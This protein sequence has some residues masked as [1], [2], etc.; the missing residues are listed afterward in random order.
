MALGALG[1]TDAMPAIARALAGELDGRTRRRMNE[2]I[3]EI[4]D[5]ARPAEEARRLHD[6][7]ERLRGETAKLR[8]RL[9]RLEA[10]L[11]AP[12][13]RPRRPRRSAPGRPPGAAAAPRAPP[14]ALRPT[15]AYVCSSATT[16]RKIWRARSSSP[17]GIEMAPTTGW[18][19][20]P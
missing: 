16:S 3:R 2:A 18:P 8:E 5:G 13:R 14:R 9:D 11:G 17:R 20:P 19:P 12:P 4:E 7:V 1:L 15:R 6:E 10:R